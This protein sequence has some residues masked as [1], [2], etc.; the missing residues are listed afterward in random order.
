MSSFMAWEPYLYAA[1]KGPAVADSGRAWV[2]RA[3]WPGS[4]YPVTTE[5]GLATTSDERQIVTLI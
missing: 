1:P 3:P 2:Q 5:D 4:A